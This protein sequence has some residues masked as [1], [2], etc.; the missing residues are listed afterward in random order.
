[1][2]C[3]R[4]HKR[5]KY[6]DRDGCCDSRKD[7]GKRR[8]RRRDHREHR[9]SAL[10]PHV[11]HCGG[12]HDDTQHAGQSNKT[13]Q[14]SEDSVVVIDSCDVTIVSDDR[15]GALNLQASLHAAILIVVAVSIF[16]GDVTKAEKFTQELT[17]T[18]KVKQLNFHET[19]VENSRDVKIEMSDRHIAI[20]IQLLL[21]LLLAVAV[22]ADIF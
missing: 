18:A 21:Q 6:C 2:Y 20:N 10:D 7:R 16:G 15:Q 8:R 22:I 12:R 1:M 5:E 17:Q 3:D 9:W 19:Y 11:K 13:V 4:C 14:I